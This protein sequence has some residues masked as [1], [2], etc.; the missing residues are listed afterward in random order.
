MLD[1]FDSFWFVFFLHQGNVLCVCARIRVPCLSLSPSPSLP[2]SHAHTPGY[3]LVACKLLMME[4]E[5]KTSSG[6]N[7]KYHKK[8]KGR[9]R[10]RVRDRQ[11]RRRILFF[12]VKQQ[13]FVEHINPNHSKMSIDHQDHY[14]RQR[15]SLLMKDPL[16]CL[17]NLHFHSDT[18]LHKDDAKRNFNR[19]KRARRRRI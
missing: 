6:M 10:A 15:H 2:M 14:Y 19:I 17:M 16:P 3:L 9:E 7:D 13:T 8:E 4:S 11:R 1:N 5:E 18:Y 12:F